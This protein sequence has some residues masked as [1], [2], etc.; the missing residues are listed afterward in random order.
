MIEMI[1]I[2]IYKLTVQLLMVCLI[3]V[4]TLGAY[5]QVTFSGS[6]TQVN[7]T[8]AN[9]QRHAETAMD[10]NGNYVVV[11]QSYDE[12]SDDFGIYGQMYFAGG[13]A[14]GAPFLVNTTTAFGQ[15]D[16]DVAMNASGMF[17]VTWSSQFEDTDGHGVWFALYDAAG[18]LITRNRVNDSSADEQIHPCVGMRYDGYFVVGYMDDGQDGDSWGISYQGFSS[19][20]VAQFAEVVPNS[21]TAGWQGHPDVAM[22]S[23]GNYIW[24]WQDYALDGSLAGI[25]M[26]RYDNNDNAVGSETQVNT[27]TSGNQINPNIEMDNDGNS[28]IAWSS[29][30]QDGDHLG[31]IGQIYDNSGA[32]VGGEIAVNSTTAGAQDWASV[33]VTSNNSYLVSWTSWG[34][35]GDKAGVYMQ[36][37]LSDGTPYGGE[38]RVNATTSLYQALPSVSGNEDTDE[39][40]VVWQ[41]GAHNSLA[42]QDGDGYGVYYQRFL[43]TDTEDPIAVCQ[44]ITVYLD[45]SG[46]ASIVATDVDGGST[47]NVGITS[48]V[49]DVSAFTCTEIGSNSVTL[50]V[51]DAAG[52]SANCVAT[53]TVADTTSPTAVCQNVTLYLDGTGNASMNASDIDGGSLDNCTTVSLAA[54]QTAFTCAEVG[55]NSVTLTVTDGSSNTSTCISTVTVVDTVSPSAVCQNITVYLDGTGS[56]TITGGDLDGG[57]SDVCGAITTAVDISSFSCSDVGSNTVTLTVTDGSGNTDACAATVTVSDT[58]SPTI[59][60]PGNQTE[61]PDASCS[62]TLPDYTSLGTAVDNC[63]SA[64]ISQSPVATTVITGNTTITLTAVDGNGNTSICTFD[65]VLNDATPPTAVCQNITV[66]LDG[67]GS[68]SIVAA[69]IDGGSTDNCGAVTIGA[70]TTAFTCAD[71]GTNNVTLTVTDGNTNSATCAAVVTVIDTVSPTAVCQNINAYLDGAGN[72]TIVAADIDGGSTDNCTTVTL[73]ASATSFTCADAGANNVTLTVTDGSA[74]TSICVAVVTVIDTISPTAICQNISVYVDGAGNASIIAADID[75][76]ST[77][78]CTAVTLATSATSF[79]C[80]DAGTN[81]V[82]LTVTDGSSNVSSCIAVVTVIDTI[83]PTAICQNISVYLDGAGNATIVGADLDGGSTDNCGAVTL[84]AATTAFTCADLGANNVTMTATDASANTAICVGIIT[85]LDT[86]SPTITCPGNQTENPDASCNFTLPDYTSLGTA[87]DNCGST[88]I[89]QSPI[90]TTVITGTT[91]ITLTADDG[92]GN[93]STC[94]FDVILSDGTAPTAV[95]QNISVYLD[96]TGNVTIADADLDGGSTDNCSGLTFS[97]SQTAFTCADLGTN[98]ITLTVTDGNSNSSNCIAVVTVIDTISPIVDVTPLADVTGECNVILTAPTATDNCAG[99]VT[100]TTTDPTTYNLEGTYI[101]T[102][103]Y[104]DGNGNTAS[105][106]QNVIVDDITAPTVTCP[107]DQTESPDASCNFTLTDYTSLVT[108]VDNCSSTITL[109]Q[110]PVTGTVINANTAVWMY[111]DDGNGNIDS[112]TFDVLL[113]DATAPTAVCQNISVYLDATG[114]VTIADTDLDGGST[115]NCSGLSFAASQTAFTCADLGTVNVTLTVTDG[116]SNSSNC[117]AI[118][119]VIDTISPVVDVTPLADVTG[120]CN[121]IVT[122]PTATDNCAGTVTATTVDP[123]TYSIEGTYVITWTYDDGNGNTASQ[124]QNVIVDDITAPTVT[125]P[126]DQTESPDASCNFTLIDYTSMVTTVDNCSSTITLTQSPITGTVI[127]GNTAIW[128]YADDGNGNIDSCTFDVLLLDATAPTAVCQDITVYLDSAGNV[129]IVDAD[130][131]GGSTDNCSGISFSASQTTFTC[132]DLGVNAITLTVTDGNGNTD[133]CSSNV[134][135]V[136]TIAP[137]ADVSPLADAIGECNV[138]ATPPTATDACTGTITATTVDPTTYNVEGTYVITWTYDDGNGNSSSQTQ[139]VIVNDT[140]APVVTCPADQNETPDAS[141]N[142]TLIDYTGM[143]T[144]TD[145]CSSSITITQSPV[146]GTV[147]NGNT[148]MWL[149]ADDGNGNVD[150]CS[151]DVL[152]LD[153][154]APTAVCQDITVYLDSAGSITI[155]DADLDGGSTDNCTGIAFTAGQT[156]FDCADLGINAILFI[157]TDANGNADSCSANV[158]VMD[159]IAPLADITP[160]ADVTGECSATATPPTATDACAGSVTA[161]TTD[162]TSYSVVGTYVITWTYDD[163]NGN[164][165]SQTQN[166]IVSDTTAPTVTC[167][168]DQNETPIANCEFVL[169]DYTGLASAIDACGG[170][171]TIVQSPAAGTSIFGNTMIYMI[172]SD[173]LGNLD[174]CSFNVILLD[175]TPPTAVCQDISAYL[176]SNGVIVISGADIDGGSTD[177][178]T[179]FTLTA[180]PNTLTCANLGVNAVNL[181]VTDGSGNADTCSSN[182]T[183]MDTL[184]PVPDVSPLLAYGECS[185]TITTPTATDNC[186]GVMNG[187]TTDPTSY[188]AQGSYTVTWTYDDGNGNSTTQIQSVTVADTTGPVVVCPGDQNETP[189]ANCEFVLPDYTGLAAAL[190]ACGGPATITQSP[191]VGTSIFGNTVIYMIGSD[192]LGNLDSCSFNVILLDVTPP[193]AVCQNATVYLDSTGNLVLTGT[194]IDGGSTDNCTGFTLSTSPSTFSC[195]DTGVVNVTLYVTDGGGN[196]DSCSATITILDSL[197][198]VADSLILADVNAECSASVTPPTATDNCSGAITGTTTDPLSYTVQGTYTVTWTFDDGTGNVSTQL[199]TVN[200]NDTTLPLIACNSDT[201]LNAATGQCDVVVNGLAP[202]SFSDNCDTLV[203]LTYALTGATVGAGSGDV[204]GTSF[205]AGITTVTYT[206]TDDNGNTDSCSFDV[207]IVDTEPPVITCA[208]DLDVALDSNCVFVLPDYTSTVTVVDNCSVTMVQSPSAGTVIVDTTTITMT[209]TDPS[210]NVDSC[211]FVVNPS[212]VTAP[213]FTCVGDQVL[214]LDDNCEA[215]IPDYSLGMNISDYCDTLPTVTQSPAV[216]TVYTSVS[217]V[218]TYVMVQDA[219]GNTDTCFFNV[220]IETDANSGCQDTLII[221]DLLTPNGDGVN[222][223]WLIEGLSLIDGCT[224]SIFN[225]WGNKLYETTSYQNE[226]DGTKD[227]KRLPDG[228]YFYVIECDGEVSYKGPVTLMRLSK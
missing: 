43:T 50:A 53:V 163:G 85:I 168:A 145:N 127:N 134:T 196:I 112:C 60:C 66:Y 156:T 48:Y 119:T 14:N 217:T 169:P 199:Q 56:A 9:D 122:A 190:D 36:G 110:S 166:V 142:F 180:F 47:D 174:S 94:T 49:V 116:N 6:E 80:A 177:N 99:T 197:A 178:C 70:S 55:S 26:Q 20:G 189:I 40:V 133:N 171:T 82:T 118:V 214:V 165:A 184:A 93:T 87:A 104:D 228:A 216:G 146:L 68:A 45:G 97:A 120:E 164:T 205:T 90:A 106:T 188:T 115:D 209:G 41:S 135:V 186:A 173:S 126:S 131:D 32:A 57:S 185:V 25:F 182:V 224:V 170:S 46:N 7:T 193:T 5:A 123:T 88:T 141:C 24:V 84:S 27:T 109:T 18:T 136:D 77:D 15:R 95:C 4:S 181:I 54:S 223:T 67:T 167:P 175:V 158:T 12:D 226:W 35:D 73:S 38:Q 113:L 69:D 153:A 72:V 150:S 218:V 192:T 30:G 148:T 114:N 86:I 100:A 28:M 220:S 111:A 76:G 92:N 16:P 58:I 144:T 147:I 202:L 108:T 219:S 78:N 132:A 65:V 222:D 155:A 101:V 210:G 23:A 39:L 51:A 71:I 105:Q 187:T 125:C 204:S 213:I 198:P 139:N 91:T 13:A 33:A 200:I 17:V 162:A 11:W 10:Q 83:S 21:T 191:A 59:T 225:R 2:T 215:I 149:Y 154:T 195:A 124:T 227:G 103:T 201:I 121:V 203:D 42:T 37:F 61:N 138:V 107:S 129:T 98:N 63:G 29:F 211:S 62:F 183:V 3:V 212:D 208:G 172:G 152:L 130:L 74:N 221:A 64:T 75:G 79:T 117:V 160:L 52:N 31:I 179:G 137:I 176:D 1:K 81:N 22:D 96:A 194:E 44:N 34:Q 161:T 206:V 19:S 140:T 128:M 102:W 143:A 151:F 157:V 159:T 207:T 8:T 89:T